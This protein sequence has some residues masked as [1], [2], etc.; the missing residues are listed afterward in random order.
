[1]QQRKVISLTWP[2]QPYSN[3]TFELLINLH[4][5]SWRLPTKLTWLSVSRSSTS[6]CRGPAGGVP[7]VRCSAAFPTVRRSRP[8]PP[9]TSFRP[10]RPSLPLRTDPASRSGGAP[11]RCGAAA[12][13]C[14]A[15]GSGRSRRSA[16]TARCRA[17]G[18]V[19]AGSARP[20]RNGGG[21]RGTAGRSG[22][23]G[24]P[25]KT[26]EWGQLRTLH[27]NHRYI[28]H[29]ISVCAMLLSKRKWWKRG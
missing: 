20:A 11:G 23:T 4:S 17:C 18:R 12:S 2:V 9:S 3:L 10:P 27:L 21:S 8:T 7:R 15:V 19:A 16:S 6:A 13:W 28:T 25:A 22:E 1:M 24:P 5:F 29:L 14:P 26:E